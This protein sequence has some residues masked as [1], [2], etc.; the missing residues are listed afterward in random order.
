MG[1]AGGVKALHN[2]LLKFFVSVCVCSLWS[3]TAVR[4][5]S[6]GV[7]AAVDGG[8][9]RRQVLP[10]PP[11]GQEDEDGSDDGHDEQEAGDGD[12]YRKVPL[13]D[14]N[15]AGVISFRRLKKKEGV[16]IGF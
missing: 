9:R 14:A 10:S 5:G 15:C 11:L 1:G 8:S 3:S 6:V 2:A 13:R 12:A 4:V 16:M 7:G